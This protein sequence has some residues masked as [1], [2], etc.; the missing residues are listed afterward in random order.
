[1]TVDDSRQYFVHPT[2]CVDE[3]AHIGA[4]TKIGISAISVLAAA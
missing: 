2:A 4:G 1:M 3:G